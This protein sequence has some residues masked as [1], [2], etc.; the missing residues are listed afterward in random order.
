MKKFAAF[1]LLITVV[2]SCKTDDSLTKTD[3]ELANLKGKVQTIDEKVHN[4]GTRIACP[5]ADKR[6]RDQSSW[7]YNEDG[8]LKESSLL[9]VN[10]NV[11]ETSKYV[12]NRKGICTGIE[13]FSGNKVI[14]REVPVLDGGRA[15]GLKIYDENK[16]IVKSFEYKYS[17]N[18][19]CETK[20]LDSDGSVTGAVINDFVDGELV[21]QTEKDGN[22]TVKTISKFIRN[23]NNDVTEYV[24]SVPQDNSEYKFLFEYEYD[25]AGNWIRQTQYYDGRIVNIVIRNI[26]Y[27][28]GSTGS[29]TT[30][31]DV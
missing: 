30:T 20:T 7:V 29:S 14:G 21:S 9:D 13:R 11:V 22:G 27:Y 26:T 1:F 5:S 8:N 2:F 3:L 16:T 31:A 28:P 17:G 4:P 18:D 19:I 6:K 10:G 12:Y 15:A 25:E 24:I 23:S